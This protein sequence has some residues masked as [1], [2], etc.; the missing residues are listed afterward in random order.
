M[1]VFVKASTYTGVSRS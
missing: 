1:N